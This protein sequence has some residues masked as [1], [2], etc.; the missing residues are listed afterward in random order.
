MRYWL[1][2]RI[3]VWKSLTKHWY[4]QQCSRQID[5]QTAFSIVI[6]SEKHSFTQTN[7]MDLFKR[8]FRIWFQNNAQ[9]ITELYILSQ[10]RAMDCIFWMHR[11]AQTKL[12]SFH[13]FW[14]PY[15]HEMI[16]HWQSHYQ[17]LNTEIAVEHPII[18]RPT[19]SNTKKS[20]MD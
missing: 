18:I 7:W 20:G 9:R 16:L 11:K 15:E 14:H 12:F 4:N 19:C 3:C 17:E 5:Q 6:C 1:R 13:L 2:L 10:A 8:I